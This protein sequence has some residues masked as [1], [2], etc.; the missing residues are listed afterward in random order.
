MEIVYIIVG[1]LIGIFLGTTV[2]E[3]KWRNNAWRVQR[4]CSHGVFF[5][6]TAI[7]DSESWRFTMTHKS[8]K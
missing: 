4:I 5:K 1:L 7:E 6:V 8:T 2:V 3:T